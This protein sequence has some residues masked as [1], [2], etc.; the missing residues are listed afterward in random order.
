MQQK[1]PK[2]ETIIKHNPK[3]ETEGGIMEMKHVLESGA[4]R[5][6]GKGNIISFITYK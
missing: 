3:N 2:T 6:S 5:Y 1:Q 4:M